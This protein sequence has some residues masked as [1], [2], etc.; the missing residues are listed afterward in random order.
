MSARADIKALV[1]RA[2]AVDAHGLAGRAMEERA[3]RDAAGRAQAE[4]DLA[5]HNLREMHALLEQRQEL[6]RMQAQKIDALGKDLGVTAAKLRAA[7]LEIERL[8]QLV[9]GFRGKGPL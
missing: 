7:E 4:L 6:D 1:E 3:L 2:L 5:H 8:N 9:L